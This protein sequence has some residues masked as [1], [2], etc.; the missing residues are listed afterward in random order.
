MNNE[1]FEASYS[2]TQNHK[3]TSNNVLVE[4]E[5]G[6]VVAVFYNDYDLKSCVTQMININQLREENE[7]L[8]ESNKVLSQYIEDCRPKL[9]PPFCIDTAG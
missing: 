1:E 9:H 5:T 4:S 2:F 3:I 6:R 8:K 7:R